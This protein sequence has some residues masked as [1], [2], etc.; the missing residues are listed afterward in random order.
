MR[1]QPWLHAL[2]YF[3]G[4]GFLVN[5]LPHFL[6]GIEGHSFQSPFANPPGEGL[7]SALVN[8]FWGAGNFVAAY[9]LLVR[10]GKFD[11]RNW[12]HILPA[13]AGGMMIAMLLV[14]SFAKLNGGL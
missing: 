5:A 1:W 8:V 3:W 9:L 6:S 4:A 11:I 7:S 13:A 12:L 10:V 14:R 2:S